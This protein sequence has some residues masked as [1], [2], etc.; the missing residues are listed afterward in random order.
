MNEKGKVVRVTFSEEQNRETDLWIYRLTE[1]IILQQLNIHPAI[2]AEL[3]RG[4]QNRI[5]KIL[6]GGR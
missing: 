5:N 6:S 2:K 1:R 4:N 3:L